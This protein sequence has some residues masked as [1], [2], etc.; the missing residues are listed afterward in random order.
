MCLIAWNW[1]PNASERL[2]LI[3]NRDENYDRPSLPLHWWGDAP[4]LAGRDLTGG[5]TWLGV[6]GAGRMAAITNHRDPKAQRPGAPSRGKLVQD[7][8]ASDQAAQTYLDRVAQDAARYNPFNLLVFD[9]AS[10]L[11]LESRRNRIVTIEPGIS[12]V[13]NADFFTPW[14][15]LRALT[16]ALS[17]LD[18]NGKTED[19]GALVTL[20]TDRTIAPDNALP[21]T[22]IPLDRERVLSPAFIAA[23]GYGTRASTILRLHATGGEMTEHLFDATGRTGITTIRF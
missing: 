13:S 5:G 10:F 20:L 22:G 18:R 4:V 12:G 3:G 15:K 16:G 23:P 7:F 2:L 21:E 11:G 6:G 19:D 8:L 14:P 9:G 17:V 1:R